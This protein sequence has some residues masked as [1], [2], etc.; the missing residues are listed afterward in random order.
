[1]NGPVKHSIDALAAGVSIA[2]IFD[3]MPKLAGVFAV[4]WY[5]IRFYEYLKEKYGKKS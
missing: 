1:M 4:I 2:G 3:F 5:L